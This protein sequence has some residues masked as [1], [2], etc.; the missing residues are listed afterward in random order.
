MSIIDRVEDVHKM[1]VDVEVER[2]EEEEEEDQVIYLITDI[3]VS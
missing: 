3:D 1:A 2:E